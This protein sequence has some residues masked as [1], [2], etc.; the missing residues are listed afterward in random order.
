M[1]QG[2]GKRI[3]SQSLKGIEMSY[4]GL[5]Q[6]EGS[7]NAFYIV[8]DKKIERRRVGFKEFENEREAKFAHR[9]Q[10]CLAQHD[11]APMVY[12]D[13]GM[14]RRHTGEFTCCGY[15]TEVA[16]PMPRCKDVDCECFQEMSSCSNSI[17]INV[18]VEELREQGL[19]YND[20]H[21][22]N[23]GYVRRKGSWVPVVIDLG[24]ES[25][26]EWDESIYGEFDYDENE[27]FAS[28]YGMCTCTA[29][30]NLRKENN[31]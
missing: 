13:V 22:G 9:I 8:K 26:T 20:A 28:D 5:Y 23:F 17:T 19:D 18:V 30:K 27:C 15:L 2:F 3:I 25:F 10:K 4:V 12:G 1:R 14:I 11:L 24:I 6:D 31:E 7:K 29:C 21:K 16:K